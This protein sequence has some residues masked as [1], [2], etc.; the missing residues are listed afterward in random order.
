[1]VG[2]A[3]GGSAP[4]VH[5]RRPV[6]DRRVEQDEDRAASGEMLQ[7]AR[8]EA[9]AEG[10]DPG[11]VLLAPFRLHDLRRDG[12]LPACS[13]SARGVEVVELCLNHVSGTY[14][15][16]RRRP[17][18]VDT[19]V[20][21]QRAALEALE[22]A[23]PAPRAAAKK[24]A[25]PYAEKGARRA[26]REPRGG[27]PENG[28]GRASRLS[29]RRCCRRGSAR[30][31]R[32]GSWLQPCPKAGSGVHS[33]KID[34]E[35]Y[36]LEE[37]GART[38]RVRSRGVEADDVRDE[39]LPRR[40]AQGQQAHRWV[41]GGPS[42]AARIRRP[43]SPPRD[44][45]EVLRQGGRSCPGHGGEEVAEERQASLQ[46]EARDVVPKPHRPAPDAFEKRL[47]AE[48]ALRLCRVHEIEPTTTKGGTLC[49]LAAALHGEPGRQTCRSTAE[50]R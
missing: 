13:G 6:A 8:E 18:S 31:W 12:P 34:G 10:R 1:M 48:A 49:A 4:G 25:W 14:R 44:L 2:D 19:L 39:D 15:G 30:R 32:R 36:R 11:K 28:G 47:A 7:V 16:H 33:D 29:A 42:A 20:D 9:E 5:R 24:D 22:R 17:T 43:E 37:A 35:L 38:A 46:N 21:E 40:A 45:R 23:H 50:L 41:A 27:E 26:G 3:R